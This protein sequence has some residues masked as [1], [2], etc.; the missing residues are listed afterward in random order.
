[1]NAPDQSI[2][3]NERETEIDEM[4]A[5]FKREVDYG[6]LRGNLKCTVE[7]RL[8]WLMQLQKFFAEMRAAGVRARHAND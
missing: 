3:P 2:A 1:M 5:A 6:L 4:I 8:I 7:Q